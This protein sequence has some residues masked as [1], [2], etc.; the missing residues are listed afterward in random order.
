MINLTNVINAVAAALAP[1][2]GIPVENF[3][4]LGSDIAQGSTPR[5]TILP[6]DIGT[7]R[8]LDTGSFKLTMAFY[9]ETF[10]GL[11]TAVSDFVDTLNTTFSQRTNGG[12]VGLSGETYQIS[13]RQPYR[14]S[15]PETFAERGSNSEAR[16]FKVTIRMEFSVKRTTR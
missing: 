13:F 3:K 6:M 12:C 16:H 11:Y 7:E 2:T 10:D 15:D 4:Y 14:I 8:T 5:G 1:A 9:S